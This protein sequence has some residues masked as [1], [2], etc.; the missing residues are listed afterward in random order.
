[1]WETPGSWKFLLLALTLAV[2]VFEAWRLRRMAGASSDPGAAERFR[3]AIVVVS[4]AV[5]VFL[6]NALPAITRVFV[7]WVTVGDSLGRVTDPHAA[8]A[9]SLVLRELGVLAVFHTLLLNVWE[10]A[11]EYVNG[12]ATPARDDFPTVLRVARAAVVVLSQIYLL[13]AA[14]MPFLVILL[15]MMFAGAA[16]LAFR[17]SPLFGFARR[18]AVAH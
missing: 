13:C 17:H 14:T 2:C 7:E 12:I 4:C 8:S 9:R 15:G 1:M 16:L 5:L 18:S 3:L 11:R 6:M 10:I